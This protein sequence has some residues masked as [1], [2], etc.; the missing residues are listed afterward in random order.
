[1][2]GTRLLIVVSFLGPFVAWI[3]VC[4]AFG[5]RNDHLLLRFL[6]QPVTRAALVGS[7][8]PAPADLPFLKAERLSSV[9]VMVAE[10]QVPFWEAAFRKLA[11]A[12]GDAVIVVGAAANHKKFRRVCDSSSDDPS[13]SAAA[14]AASDAY[15]ESESLPAIEE[16][17][18]WICE[19]WIPREKPRLVITGDA[20]VVFYPTSLSNRM[21]ELERI[22]PAATSAAELERTASKQRWSRRLHFTLVFDRSVDDWKDYMHTVNDW[23]H[24][25]DFG[26]CISG[27]VVDVE[28]QRTDSLLS[29]IH[30]QR[31]AEDE[32]GTDY[33]LLPMKAVAES[34]FSS[35]HTEN[36]QQQ[37]IVLYIPSQSVLL[38]D[39][40]G[41]TSLQAAFGF[42]NS[43]SLFQ[44]IAMDADD[45]SMEAVLLG[46]RDHVVTKC[47]GL[48]SEDPFVSIETAGA[49]SAMIPA[50][51]ERIYH[52]RTLPLLYQVVAESAHSVLL[53]LPSTVAIGPKVVSQYDMA[54]DCQSE[55][56][57]H[58]TACKYREAVKE[59]DKA[60]ALLQA[61]LTDPGLTEP[62]DFPAEQY[63]AIFAPLLI[64]LLL[65]L[66][67][68]LL[69]EYRRYRK[70]MQKR[71]ALEQQL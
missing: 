23:V 14:A 50:F 65:P 4:I 58:A 59:L 39:E 30:T 62:M 57:L 43:S 37:R 42:G 56:F 51:Y 27:G 19:F 16:A 21:E 18:L 8:A 70:L 1:M 36:M 64:P 49:A 25:H 7:A 52:G 40:E 60:D 11:R 54:M 22:Y 31:I 67:A 6:P 3:A 68:T 24:R 71:M 48:P 33:N 44:I 17:H 61:L 34:L 66:V 53:A 38:V 35:S 9:F 69:R 29:I 47:F 20:A 45:S 26:P 41:A 15:T 5:L 13:T 28:V 55:A 46:I 12:N 63:A 2:A 10:S 32:E